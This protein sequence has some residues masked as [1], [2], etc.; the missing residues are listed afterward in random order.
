MYRRIICMLLLY[1][2]T[3]LQTIYGQ[4]EQALDVGDQ[5]PD[6]PL[7]KI[8]NYAK[9]TGV[10]LSD[11]LGKPVLLDFWATSCGA[12]IEAFPKMEKLQQEFKNEIQILLVNVFET[13]EAAEDRMKR[14]T[15]RSRISFPDLPRVYQND[16]LAALFP[17][18]YIPH[19]VWLD[20]NGKVVSISSGYNS[21][22]ELVRQILGG[23]EIQVKRKKD[24][25]NID[26]SNGFLQVADN[27]ID[28][29]LLY[30]SAILGIIDGYGSGTHNH[31]NGRMLKRTFFNLPALDL[32]S[33]AYHPGNGLN[34]F[35]FRNRVI[36]DVKNPAE[37]IRPKDYSLLDTW[38]ENQI[39]TYEIQV[40]LT[41]KDKIHTIMQAD[42]NRYFSMLK[43]VE[44]KLVDR[45]MN[46]LVLQLVDSSMLLSKT[47]EKY[48]L[49]NDSILLLKKR[50]PHSLYNFLAN[51]LKEDSRPFIND[52]TL[53]SAIDIELHPPFNDLKNLQQQLRK[54]GLRLVEAKR[55][56]PMLR[57][58]DSVPE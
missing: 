38:K 56:I 31:R 51:S 23:K 34:T 3:A 32:F 12:C 4:Y 44:A 18:K 54:F 25:L 28:S 58:Y 10:R 49:S 27:R 8:N 22:P 20:K 30:Y 45:E 19:H 29:S 9:N 7:D 24:L 14:I 50:T 57:I 42:L 47:G 33:E 26:L 21:T 35:R 1:W 55:V 17:C 37:W 6:I 5:C 46:C 2:V 13:R 53:K 41:A 16:S 11:F 36:L 15:D 39:F 43:G 40:P 48:F 52:V